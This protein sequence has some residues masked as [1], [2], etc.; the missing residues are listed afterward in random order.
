[1]QPTPQAPFAVIVFL[2]FALLLV[3]A[4]AQAAP[5]GTKGS[6]AVSPFC[7]AYRC[8][9]INKRGSQ[10]YSGKAPPLGTHHAYSLP[11]FKGIELWTERLP[12]GT[13]MQA[14]LVM[15]GEVWHKVPVA[16][17]K[18]MIDLMVRDF[19]G[20]APSQLETTN[21]GGNPR[22]DQRYRLNPVEHCVGLLDESGGWAGPAHRGMSCEWVDWRP[23]NTY[24]I[25]F[26]R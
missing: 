14:E 20:V 4:P 22:T 7:K 26:Y 23:E 2:G 16:T 25:G 18:K 24:V 8:Q 9:L 19:M 3:H 13:L 21:F 5:L 1:S 10:L 17:R 15:A 12:D 6:V 11:G